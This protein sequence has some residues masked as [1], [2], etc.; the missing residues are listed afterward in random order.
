[1]SIQTVIQSIQKKHGKESIMAMGDSP[2]LK[3]DVIPTGCI[4]IDQGIGVGGFPRGRI[5]DVFGDNGVGKSSLCMHVTASAQKMGL[6][7]AYVDS[8]HALDA[9]YAVNIGVDL[10][11]LILSQPDSAEQGL[12]IVQELVESGEV[13]LIIVDSVAALVPQAEIDGE[14]GDAFVGLQSRLMSQACRKLT[15]LVAKYNVCLVFTNQLRDKI[16]MTG[17]GGETTTQ[18]G[19]RALKFYS[20]LRM[21]LKHIQQ[22]KEKEEI[23]GR[24]IK[25]KIVKNKLAPP[26]K[27]IEYDIIFGEGINMAGDLIDKAVELKIV[28]K[29]GAWY[30]YNGESIGQG[31]NQ[32]CEYLKLNEDISD[33][34]R[35]QV[36]E[37]LNPSED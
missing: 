2:K 34:I 13:A 26:F 20:S 9:D 22:L 30:Y 32:A 36:A 8:E 25:M 18:P 7:C 17:Y 15:S 21:D 12:K 11:N 24:R 16:G 28:D 10:N 27:E 35:S 19:G 3:V 4:S 6:L 1:M 14:I 5:I 29:K 33:E 37:S 23:T 31:R